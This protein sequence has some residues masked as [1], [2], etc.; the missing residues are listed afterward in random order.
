MAGDIFS[1]F[2]IP[3][4][5]NDADSRKVRKRAETFCKTQLSKYSHVLYT[6]GNH[7]SWR[8]AIEDA[9]ALLRDFLA[10]RASNLTL[11]DNQSI[12]I[13]GVT[14]MG[15]TLW[16]RCGFGTAEEW[17]INN[18][19]R[20]FS[21]IRTR[22]P[23]STPHRFFEETGLRSFQPED[24]H[25]LYTEAKQ[26]LLDSTPT[27]RPVV[28]ITHHAP[29]FMSGHGVDHGAAYLDDAYCGNLVDFFVDRP[30]IKLAVHGHTHS[31]EHY[32]IG[33]TLVISNPRGYFPDERLSRH[34]DPTTE[35]IDTQDWETA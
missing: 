23:P 26:W 15:T 28:V 14:F 34:F 20:D 31:H 5:R 27:D 2:S 13:G 9:P 18:A 19:M 3:A 10:S 1:A 25:S 22:K 11:L 32:R 30:N 33:E 35:D 24:A 17:R 21:R 4:Q 8:V 7:D 12:E 29:S 16:A 6:L